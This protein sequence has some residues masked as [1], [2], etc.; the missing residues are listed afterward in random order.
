MKIKS[1]KL[2]GIIFSLLL[3]GCSNNNVNNSVNT[4]NPNN[5]HPSLDSSTILDDTNKN[6]NSDKITGTQI[7]VEKAFSSFEELKI[8]Y[9]SIKSK[10]N[11]SF[12]IPNFLSLNDEYNVFYT[13]KGVCNANDFE[14]NG[15][16][17][18]YDFFSFG[19][20]VYSLDEF[21]EKETFYTFDI[22]DSVYE[23]D[24]SNDNVSFQQVDNKYGYYKLFLNDVAFMRVIFNDSINETIITNSLNKLIDYLTMIK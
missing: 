2:G 23:Y 1:L 6:S 16:I 9:D 11:T 22:L 17:V 5:T 4:N 10:N 24:T 13:F 14:K 20:E 21:K 7:F 15:F 12:L 18:E 19:G 3:I 8:F